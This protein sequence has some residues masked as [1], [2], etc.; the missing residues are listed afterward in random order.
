MQDT[1]ITDKGMES[2]KRMTRLE[3]FLA[4]NGT[5]ITDAGLEHIKGMTRLQV[6]TVGGAQVTDAGVQQLKQS[7]PKLN[8]VR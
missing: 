4:L 8:V 1:Q 5:K 6:L 2:L 3:Q 7:L